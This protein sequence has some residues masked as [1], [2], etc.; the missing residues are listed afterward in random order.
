MARI[1]LIAGAGMLPVYWAEAAQICGAEIITIG[2]TPSTEGD[3]LQKYSSTYHA[4]SVGEL[5]NII[6]TL[7]KEGITEAVMMGKVEKSLMF[8]G[9]KMDQRLMKLLMGLHVKNDDAILLALVNELAG[10]GIY[11]LEQTVYMDDFV[12][13][14]GNLL[15]EIAITPELQKDMEYGFR[16]AKEVGRLDIGQTVVVKDTAAIA[17][18]AI[19][20][21]DQTIL[22]SGNLT[23]GAVVAKV[24]KPAQDFRF[25]LPTIG[26]TTMEN[27]VKVGAKGL[28][29][30]ADRTFF[31]ERDEVLKLAQANGIAVLAM[32]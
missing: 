14:E 10:E 2:I 27:L 22:R 11:F 28:V 9:L 13:R 30:E 5:D 8:Q 25:D 6:A 24:S 7:K 21:T 15:P 4:I 23:R 31:I 16:L 1:G 32:R 26:L 12:A 3:L 19:E 18:E 29:L 17:V 20:G